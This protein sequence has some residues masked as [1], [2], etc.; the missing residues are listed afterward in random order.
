MS[1]HMQ[2]PKLNMYAKMYYQRFKKNSNTY[3]QLK[4]FRQN[5]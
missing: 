1:E 3:K 2:D 5:Y 4:Y